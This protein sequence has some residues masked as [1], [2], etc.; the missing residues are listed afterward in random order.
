M[1]LV[2][3]V[4]AGCA[5][6]MKNRVVHQTSSFSAAARYSSLKKGGELGSVILYIIFIGIMTSLSMRK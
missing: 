6:P 1:V 5:D 4:K 3:F 2:K